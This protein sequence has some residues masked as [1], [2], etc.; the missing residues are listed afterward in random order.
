MLREISEGLQPPETKTEKTAL[1]SNFEEL[2]TSADKQEWDEVYDILNSIEEVTESES[3]FALLS[4]EDFFR[5]WQELVALNIGVLNSRDS[6]TLKEDRNKAN[7]I[8]KIIENILDNFKEARNLY[9]FKNEE[10]A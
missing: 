3:E 10:E 9:V 2:K 5:M 6:G 4:R 7:K 8:D 1:I